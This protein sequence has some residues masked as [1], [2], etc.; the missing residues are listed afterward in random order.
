[1]SLPLA[2]SLSNATTAMVLSNF[3]HTRHCCWSV[4]WSWNNYWCCLIWMFHKQRS[5]L[6]QLHVTDSTITASAIETAPD[7]PIMLAMSNIIS[8]NPVSKEVAM[9]ITALFLLSPLI[10]Q[11]LMLLFRLHNK[12]SQL[13][14]HTVHKWG[15]GG[16]R[17]VK[18]TQ[19]G[20]RAF[21]TVSRRRG[22]QT[23]FLNSYAYR[24]HTKEHVI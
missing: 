15:Y 6:L 12:F 1:M 18:P 2:L 10:L 13:I 19:K 7:H 20:R 21:N 4:G 23:T 11:L 8:N 22:V 24:S 3:N 5:L 17:D 9:A 14:S 16:G